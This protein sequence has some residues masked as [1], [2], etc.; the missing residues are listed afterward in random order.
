MLV[1]PSP[2]DVGLPTLKVGGAALRLIPAILLYALI[3]GTCY[4]QPAVTPAPAFEPSRVLPSGGDRPIPLAPGLL[5]SIYGEHLGPMMGCEGQAD[6]QHRETPSPLRPRQMFVDTL[7]YPKELCDTQ[8]LVGGIPAGLLYVQ[9]RQ[10]NFKVPQETPV[11]GATAVKVVYKG[12]SSQPATLPL[13][14]DSVVLSLESPAK[15]GMPVWLKVS[16][17]GW[18]RSVHYPFDI[19]PANFKCHE[20]EV[21]RDGM[22]LPR[23]A[24]LT[25]QAFGGI[26]MSGPPCGFLGLPAESPHVGRIPLH[27]RYR[28]DQPGTY[29]VRYTM[30]DLFRTGSATI[31]SAW[32]PIEVLA[33]TKA[34]RLQWLKELSA[35]AP[36][37]TVEL[38]TDY[39]PAILGTP[40][41]PSLDLLCPYLYHADNLVRQFAMYGLT[42]WPAPEAE[43][44]VLDA[45]RA[46]GPSD[47]AV[48]FLIR[49]PEL[50]ATNGDSLVHGA[51]PYLRS[52]SPVLLRGAVTAIYRAAL[53]ETARVTPAVRARAETAMLQAADHVASVA[54]AQTVTDYAA[55]LGVIKDPR[56]SA[57]LW[58]FTDRNVARG[59]AVIALTWRRSPA[60]LPKLAQ[61]TLAPT[62]GHDLDSEL[63]S[64]PYAIHRAYGDAA[65]PYLETM[66]KR[67]EF[68]WVRTGSARELMLAG[69][70]AGFAFV[71]D[72]IENA[73]RYRL[74]MVE[75]VRGQF[76]ELRHA[77]DP[78]VLAFVKARATV[79]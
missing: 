47:V 25:S 54:D 68:T 13:G 63:S 11:E 38:L 60:D 18:D 19:F 37:D 2:V 56:A 39:L 46:R 9:E 8:V 6:P 5:V 52:D 51:I 53:P 49:R 48:Q 74:E 29:E 10:I 44:A 32:T 59:Q 41:K 58:D 45:V 34:D 1:L 61:L 12:Q 75:W 7:I 27:L 64:L 4:G 28:F 50:A 66:L 40:D 26:A 73:R 30:R 67:S 21:R 65:I 72:A 3:V 24:T 22:P 78:A 35:H 55:A 71:A 20:V 76:Q 17:R 57:V 33:G 42:Y 62:D 36:A 16:M 69:R 23:S 14:L 15:V 70:P 43:S 79:R 31:E 77:D